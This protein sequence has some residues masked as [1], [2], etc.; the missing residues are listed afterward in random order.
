VDGGGRQAIGEAVVPAIV[1]GHFLD[2]FH[3]G[4]G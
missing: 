4:D 1:V 2:I 3:W